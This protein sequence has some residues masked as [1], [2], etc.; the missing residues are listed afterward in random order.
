MSLRI[1]FVTALA[2]AGL[3]ASGAEAMATVA[4]DEMTAAWQVAKIQKGKVTTQT[5]R[6]YVEYTTGDCDLDGQDPFF[7]RVEVKRKK[8]RIVLTVVLAKPP[9][10]PTPCP[11]IALVVR[12]RVDLKGK[13]GKRQLRDGSYT[14]PRL[15]RR[16]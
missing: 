15:V 11:A 9:P 12:K 2:V 6:L 10:L 8:Q 14:P 5:R 4:P 16:K 3:L 1:L 13:L 7:R